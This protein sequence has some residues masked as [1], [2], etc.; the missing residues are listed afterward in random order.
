MYLRRFVPALPEQARPYL[1]LGIVLSLTF[2]ARLDALLLAGVL[3]LWLAGREGQRGWSGRSL[4]RLLAFGLPLV[5]SCAAYLAVT[6]YLSG[7]PAPVSGVIK[8]SWSLHLLAEDPHYVAHGWLVAKL[9][10]LAVPVRQ[11][12]SDWYY[13][14]IVLGHG[15]PG[16]RLHR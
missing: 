9:H 14:P 10:H 16:N 6:W 5:L 12:V 4:R 13:R 11:F 2:L 1:T 3:G 8:R 15:L 7:H